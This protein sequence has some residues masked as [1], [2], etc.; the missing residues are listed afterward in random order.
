MISVIR[1][2]PL[3]CNEAWR[4]IS[5][6]EL[7]GVMSNKCPGFLVRLIALLQSQ[8]T[9]VLIAVFSACCL[10]WLPTFLPTIWGPTVQAH[11]HPVC[12]CLSHW[13]ALMK[14]DV[15]IKISFC[16]ERTRHGNSGSDEQTAI[17]YINKGVTKWWVV[18]EWL[19]NSEAATTKHAGSEPMN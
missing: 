5:V 9:Q 2:D 15:P 11:E 6:S 10:C 12:L 13:K 18:C 16:T 14:P 4:V 3:S 7:T 8:E 19:D 1:P 17:C